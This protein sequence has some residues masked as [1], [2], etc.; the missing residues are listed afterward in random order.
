MT[1]IWHRA[2]RPL[3][4]GD[5][6]RPRR[7][8]AEPPPGGVAGRRKLTVARRGGGIVWRGAELVPD[9]EVVGSGAE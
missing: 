2:D 8:G 7:G 1:Q 3:R 4:R 9:A 5:A 6:G